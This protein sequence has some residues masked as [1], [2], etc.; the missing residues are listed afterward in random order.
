VDPDDYIEPDMFE[1]L[2]KGIQE[3][4]ADVSCCGFT[5]VLKKENV[6]RVCKDAPIV[7]DGKEAVRRQIETGYI[8]SVFWN[9][10]FIWQNLKMQL[11]KPM[12]EK[13]MRL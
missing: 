3:N 8:K 5:K 10:L 12:A 1:Y 4:D 2:L 9:K 6:D 13:A 11:L 7:V